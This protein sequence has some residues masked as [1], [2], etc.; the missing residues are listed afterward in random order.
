MKTRPSRRNAL[1]HLAAAGAAAAVGPIVIRGQSAPIRIAGMP[2]EIAV[3]SISPVTVRVTVSAIAG[4]GGVPDDGALV[5]AAEA[6]P[7]ARRREAF[8]P[9]RAGTLS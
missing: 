1:K 2:V 6:K 7:L 5:A 3:A 8:A 4:T 9:V